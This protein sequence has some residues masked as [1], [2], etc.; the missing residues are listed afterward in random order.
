MFFKKALMFASL[1]VLAVGGIIAI[2]FFGMR[3]YSPVGIGAIPVMAPVQKSVSC[4]VYA[5][6]DVWNH[7]FFL[8]SAAKQN[9]ELKKALGDVLEQN[10]QCK[11]TSLAN[12]RMRYMLNFRKK[13]GQEVLV[14]EVIAKDP[15]PW[16]KSLVIDKGTQ[17]GVKK[18]LPVVVPEGIAGI[19]T[20]AS[21]RYSK[22]QMIIDR[23]A[24]VDALVQRSRARGILKGN[25]S[26]QCLFQYVPRKHDVEVGDTL[27]SSGLD[28]VF[29]K[30]LRVG[31]VSVVNKS[32]TGIFQEVVVSPYADFEKLEEVLVVLNPPK[33]EFTD[34]DE[35][36]E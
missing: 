12:I 6:K 28:G 27:V 1:I 25:A 20:E 34:E 5:I 24:A 13:T 4:V 32:G 31:E 17:D 19:I 10:N 11:E 3:G 15:S 26:G 23:N 22:V 18:G 16:F 36:E 21:S 35:D 2:S 14:A 29:P 33:Y 8:V 9:D 7:Y 30:G